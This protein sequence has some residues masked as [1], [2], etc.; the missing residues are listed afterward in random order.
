MQ[1]KGGVERKHMYNTFNMGIGMIMVADKENADKAIEALA[2]MGEKAYII[3]KI[4]KG[5]REVEIC[6]K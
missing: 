2:A 1:K 6:L 3:G 5:E 4:T